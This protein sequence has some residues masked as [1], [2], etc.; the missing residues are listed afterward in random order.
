[1]AIGTIGWIVI[2]VIAAAVGGL[3]GWLVTAGRLQ[4]V[5]TAL[6]V[7]AEKAEALL[8]NER[9]VYITQASTAVTLETRMREA[10]AA[11][12][13]DA[14]QANSSQVMERMEAT[15]KVRQEVSQSEL[16]GLLTPLQTSLAEYR[17][18]IAAIEKS[19]D[20]DYG[21]LRQTLQTVAIDQQ[22]LREETQNLVKALRQPQVRG[23]WGEMQLKRAIELAGM[24]GLCDYLEQATNT[25]SEG[26]QQRP[27][28]RIKLP[29]NR[30]IIVDA[31][32]PMYAYLD[33]VES[34]D[35]VTRQIKFG[36]HAKQVRSHIS[37]LAG[38]DYQ[39]SI[40]G[41]YDFVVLFI[42]GEVFYNAALEHDSELLEY[43]FGKKIILANPGTLIGLLKAVALGWQET[44]LAENA[45]E[46]ERIGNEL[47][48]RLGTLTD[49]ITTLGGHLN[50]ATDTYN[51]TVG[52][53]E[54]NFLTSA[55]RMHE[56]HVGNQPI[57]DPELLE[58]R[59]N[60]P[61]D[62]DLP[63]SQ[64]SRDD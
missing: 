41:A 24:S 36:E 14:L 48:K 32:A 11:L 23:R 37:L 45:K 16:S 43:A 35:D 34:T 47:Y 25:T 50:K 52:S 17:Q 29:N 6:T 42:P 27:D 56:L 46:I 40:D 33:A 55:R 38:K 7:R 60:L 15:L 9:Q 20:T 2:S 8:E 59:A 58:S 53:L 21:G 5:I 4:R 63:A 22:R 13:N 54:R 51:K 28:V 3:V 49:H 19:R 31:K 44:R 12:S 64:L 57:K 62:P 1:M 26:R 30:C 18:Q 61:R 10:F 39:E